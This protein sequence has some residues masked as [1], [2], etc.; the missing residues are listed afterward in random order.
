M[1]VIV[2]G[3]A[4]TATC[5]S[6]LI[7]VPATLPCKIKLPSW[8]N[9]EGLTLSHTTESGSTDSSLN[10]AATMEGNVG[11]SPTKVLTLAGAIEV[12]TAVPGIISPNPSFT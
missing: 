6:A 9:C 7:A 11:A 5:A 2:A 1:F 12:T 10:V 3:S 8:L 4:T